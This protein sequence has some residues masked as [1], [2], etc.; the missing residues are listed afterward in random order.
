MHSAVSHVSVQLVS[1]D[2]DVKM[3]KSSSS[4]SLLS[5]HSC[6][7]SADPCASQPCM[8]QGTCI[9]ENGGFRCTCPAGFS[10]AR[11]EIRDPCQSN[12]CTNGGTCQ[13]VSDTGSYQCICPVGYNGSQCEIRKPT[14]DPHFLEC[15]FLN[16]D[17]VEC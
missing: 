14:I 17:H 8:N 16:M 3:V 1:K 15:F 5:F 9:R 4:H 12:P 11:C 13:P 6:L 10:G 7:C 2:N